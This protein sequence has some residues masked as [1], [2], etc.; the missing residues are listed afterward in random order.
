MAWDAGV[1]SMDAALFDQFG[2][3]AVLTRSGQAAEPDPIRII[4]DRGV[5]WVGGEGQVITN[6]TTVS[7]LDTVA[8]LRRGDQMLAGSVRFTV[9]HTHT[10]QDGIRSYVV[11]EKTV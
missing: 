9:S 7:V 8:T 11:Q 5:E 10:D 1:A 4:V 6:A 3:D 2:E